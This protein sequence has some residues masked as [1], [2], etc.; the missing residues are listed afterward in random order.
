MRLTEEGLL[1]DQKFAQ[2]WVDMRQRTAPRSRQRLIAELRQKGLSSEAI[3][4]ATAPL[5]GDQS[6]TVRELIERKRLRTKYA[7]QT[8]RLVAYLSRQGFGYS[9]IRRALE[10]LDVGD[11]EQVVQ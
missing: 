3:E 9:D 11:T 6:Q 7:G 10:S 5:A 1:G 8:E 2:D 4:Q